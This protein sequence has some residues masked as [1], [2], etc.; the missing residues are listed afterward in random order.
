MPGLLFSIAASALAAPAPSDGLDLTHLDTPIVIDG[1]LD[2]DGWARAA[3][4]TSFQRFLPT[5]GGAHDSQ[6]EVRVAQ[7]DKHLYVGVRVTGTSHPPVARIAPREDI[8][9]DDQI[10][11]YVDPFHDGRGGYIFYFNA[12]GI[13]QD[14]RF[15]FGQWY[16]AWNTVL[17]AEGSIR[18]DGYTLEVAIPFR[19]LRYPDVEGSRGAASQTWGVMVTRKI[20]DEGI[21]LAWPELQPN[22]PRLFAQAASLRGVRP[23]EQGTGLEIQPVLAATHQMAREE[24]TAPLDWTGDD[25][26]WTD[27]VRPGV[28]ARWAITPDLGIATTINPD[29]SQVEGDIQQINLNQRFAFF[30]P[31]QRPFFL[32]GL[33]AYTDTTETLYTRSVVDPLY[34]VKLSGRQGP[35][36]LG[37][38]HALDQSPQATIHELGS[39]GFEEDEVTDRVAS[40]TFARTRFDVVENGYIGLSV[41]DKRMLEAPDFLGP[42]DGSPP[43]TTTSGYNDLAIADAQVPIGETWTITGF[44]GGSISGNETE[45]IQGFGEGITIRRSPPLGT[46]GRLSLSDRTEGFRNE[47]GFL[48]QSGITNGGGDLFQRIQLGDGK[49][50]YTPLVASEFFEERDG[51]AQ[52]AISTS[53]AFNLNGIHR[54]ELTA[55]LR[56]YEQAGV[57]MQGWSS[58]LE[59]AGRINNALSVRSRASTGR[60][61]DFGLLV[62][63]VSYRGNIDLVVRPTT[64]LRVD[65]FYVR[66]WYQPD[67]D[68]LAR[69][70]RIYTRL[71][72]QLNRAWG[73]RVVGAT[74]RGDELEAEPVFASFLLTWLK[75]PGT[76]AY[77]GATWNSAR[78]SSLPSEDGLQE[79]VVFAKFSKLFRL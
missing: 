36:G 62:P 11:I 20:P 54:P 57:Q 22:H 76:E 16:P 55:E 58:E 10:G 24:P 42:T 45:A 32:N 51:D 50:T 64:R 27:S 39:P 43:P 67:G 49:S 77:L 48:T 46:G 52:R 44:A 79:Q 8:N 68:D 7:D 1:S 78:N 2:D 60:E 25:L 21:K 19:S 12:H 29:F 9:N 6:T 70:S 72:Y 31:E 40:T 33:E 38:L 14:V 59:Y 74:T 41:A 61:L 63:A 28:D 73:M 23:P 71:N 13:Q 4:V 37:F 26:P 17:F 69:A 3:P 15:A 75:S 5:P 66:Q 35:L 47:M 53:H 56:S 34:G 30:Y 18:D 65:A